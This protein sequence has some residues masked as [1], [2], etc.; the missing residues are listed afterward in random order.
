M[1]LVQG[2]K[3]LFLI[4]DGV[5]CSYT[6]RNPDFV[7][8]MLRAGGVWCSQVTWIWMTK[9][10]SCHLHWKLS[11]IPVTARW[12]GVSH[13]LLRTP[14]CQGCIFRGNTA[15]FRDLPE[16]RAKVCCS[17]GAQCRTAKLLFN[18]PLGWIPHPTGTSFH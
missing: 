1:F 6:F 15:N 11:H 14:Y 3:C 8:Q 7:V 2:L 10:I 9:V 5:S 4:K 18:F 16:I 13:T 12:I 17:G